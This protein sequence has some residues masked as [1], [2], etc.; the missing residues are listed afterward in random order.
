MVLTWFVACG[1]LVPRP[2]IKPCPLHQKADSKPPDH[3]GSLSA[4]YSVQMVYQCSLTPSR[5]VFTERRNEKRCVS[6][7]LL[8]YFLKEGTSVY[9]YVEQRQYS[10]CV[11]YFKD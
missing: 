6:D 10:N 9:T 4:V 2:G 5:S 8:K 1:I 3:Q 7:H 11:A